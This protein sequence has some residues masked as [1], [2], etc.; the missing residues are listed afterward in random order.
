MTATGMG[1]RL[2]VLGRASVCLSLL[3]ADTGDY[4]YQDFS[5]STARFALFHLL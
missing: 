4:F 5:L 2:W 3:D 1:V